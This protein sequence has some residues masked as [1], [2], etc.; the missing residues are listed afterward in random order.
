M[1]KKKLNDILAENCFDA[2]VD[3]I[4]KTQKA[5]AAESGSEQC[6]NMMLPNDNHSKCEYQRL[7][8]V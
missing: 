6:K 5:Q 7:G 2:L 8:T 3:E 1:L 4:N